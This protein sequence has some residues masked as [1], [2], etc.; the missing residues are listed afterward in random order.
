M[1]IPIE[2]TRAVLSTRDFMFALLDPKQTP[3]VP[4]AVRQYASRCLRH[5]P[6]V[7]D[8]KLAADRCPGSWGQPE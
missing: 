1:T 6:G 8:L 4:R 3:R 2:R 5:Y 7:F